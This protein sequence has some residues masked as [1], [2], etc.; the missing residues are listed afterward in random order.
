M[1]QKEK[2]RHTQISGTLT[3]SFGIDEDGQDWVVEL[4]DQGYI[5][6][7]LEPTGRRL[8]R[9]EIL[10]HSRISVED[11]WALR[12]QELPKPQALS[13]VEQVFENLIKKLPVA[14]FGLE[15]QREQVH[16]RLMI[17][18]RNQLQNHVK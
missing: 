16:Y 12:D 18:L 14:D 9:G 8:K 15:G 7:R 5:E 13:E 1:S 11:L 4:T 17:W 6:V 3:R 10:P 2:S